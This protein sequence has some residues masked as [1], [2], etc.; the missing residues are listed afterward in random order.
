LDDETI[1]ERYLHEPAEADTPET[2]F[3][4]SWM[5]T[6]IAQAEASLEK[7]YAA[8]KKRNSSPVFGLICTRSSRRQLCGDRSGAWQKRGR[9]QSAVQRLRQRFQESLR[10]HVAQTVEDPADMRM[11][12]G[13]CGRF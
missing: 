11:S 6:L 7:D 5:R 13:I 10:A 9:H 1:E 2:L 12:Y 8:A 3:E 4:L